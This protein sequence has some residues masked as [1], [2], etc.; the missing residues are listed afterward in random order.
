[1]AHNIF[2]RVFE[3]RSLHNV[4]L[5]S[6]PKCVEQFSKIQE[7]F[8]RLEKSFAEV[9]ECRKEIDNREDSGHGE[10]EQGEAKEEDF[11]QNDDNEQ[12]DVIHNDENERI[13]ITMMIQMTMMMVKRKILQKNLKKKVIMEMRMRVRIFCHLRVYSGFTQKMRRSCQLL[14]Q[15]VP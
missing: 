4:P 6:H 1:M 12:E 11:D 8:Q 2:M 13:S 5:R 3:R 14:L 15:I 9:K 7:A 10:T